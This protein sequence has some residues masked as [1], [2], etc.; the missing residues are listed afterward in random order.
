MKK[1]RIIIVS[2]L[3]ISFLTAG[4]F[5]YSASETQLNINNQDKIGIIVSIPP[6]AEF[7]E[8]IGGDKVKV[9]TMVP[10]GANPHTYEP[11]PEQLK[12]VSNAKIYAQIGSGLEF[13]TVWMDKLSARKQKHA[14][15]K[16]F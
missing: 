7:V 14:R 8:K 16:Q 10:P 1:R 15:Y 11:L 12:E 4:M 13:E 9:T 3:I 5:I 2:I 6:E